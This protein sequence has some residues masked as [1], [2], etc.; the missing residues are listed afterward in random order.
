MTEELSIGEIYD[1]LPMTERTLLKRIDSYPFKIA[2][3]RGTPCDWF[4]YKGNKPV[5]VV[6]YYKGRKL[7]MH[8]IKQAGTPT[9]E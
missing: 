4:I 6:V 1:I 5:A 3:D 8:G 2:N 7:V 9:G